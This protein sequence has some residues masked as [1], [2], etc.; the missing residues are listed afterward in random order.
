LGNQ[1]TQ[2]KKKKKKKK[3]RGWRIR[4]ARTRKRPQNALTMML[5]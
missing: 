1:N 5:W 4:P 2:P 3:N